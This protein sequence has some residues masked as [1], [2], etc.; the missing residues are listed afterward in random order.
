MTK[1][2][3]VKTFLNVHIETD[4]ID[5]KDQDSRCDKSLENVDSLKIHKESVHQNDVDQIVE[6]LE[7]EENNGGI[8]VISPSCSSGGR[9]LGL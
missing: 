3:E 5:T 6:T 4:H 8:I 2:L 9:L 7:R 1:P